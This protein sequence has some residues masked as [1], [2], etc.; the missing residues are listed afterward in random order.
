MLLGAMLS[1]T[2]IHRQYA[3]HDT[4]TQVRGRAHLSIRLGMMLP[5]TKAQLD[6]S[7][8]SFLSVLMSSSSGAS[9]PGGA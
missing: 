5:R 1:G 8:S 2:A 9:S 3:L 7:T 4:V 6:R